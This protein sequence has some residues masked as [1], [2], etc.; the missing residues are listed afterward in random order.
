[1][2]IWKENARY[3]SK[4]R[5]NNLGIED[6]SDGRLTEHVQTQTYKAEEVAG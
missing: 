6:I 5:F 4:M 1:M 3:K 2:R